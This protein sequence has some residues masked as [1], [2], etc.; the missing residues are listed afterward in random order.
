M[1]K[2]EAAPFKLEYR[3]GIETH[4]KEDEKLR[5]SP[6][7]AEDKVWD[8]PASILVSNAD[9]YAEPSF[10]SVSLQKVFHSCSSLFPCPS[11]PSRGAGVL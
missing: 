5:V 2:G 3:V 4:V 9:E 1:G 10:A 6:L 11:F 7:T 8:N